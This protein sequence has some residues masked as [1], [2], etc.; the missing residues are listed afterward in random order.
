M[1]TVNICVVQETGDCDPDPADP[2]YA[3]EEATDFVEYTTGTYYFSRPE[4]VVEAE[5]EGIEIG[6]GHWYIGIQPD[7]IADDIAYA[8]TA[9]LKDC[10]HFWGAPYWGY[11]RWTPGSNLGYNYDLAWAI[12]GTTGGAPSPKAWIQPGTE[13]IDATVMNYGTF[14][15]EDLTCYAEIWEYITDPE[16]GTQVYSDEISNIDLTTPLGGSRDLQFADF[17]FADEGRYGLFLNLP[18]DPDD[19]TKNNVAKWGVAVDDTNPD[20]D[21][22]PIFDPADPTGEAGW[23][24][25]D[26]TVTLNASD[27]WSNGVSSGVKE[28]RYTINGG[29]EKVI[30]D[31]TGSFVLTEDGDDIEI[32]YWAV[33]WVGNVEPTKNT[34][35]IDIDQTVPEVDL[36][37]EVLGWT[38]LE[39]W[40][41]QFTATATD[42]MS[43]MESVEFYFNNELQSTVDGPGPTY[44]FTVFYIPLPGNAIFRSRAYDI[45]GLFSDDEIINPE[46]S[47]HSTPQTQISQDLPHQQPLPR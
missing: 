9:D 22:P 13:D 2:P 29:A 19:V 42:A 30:S 5:F 21:Y 33:D 7:G 23:Y 3:L 14:A 40:E 4:V 39:G 10:V 18:A 24:V 37:Y 27:P 17:T 44:V 34:I 16:N 6:P 47:S 46:T 45:A 32:Q 12:Y 15:Y 36:I 8:L 35:T 43:G 25:D 31:S 11:A 28:I 26:V 41:F 20:S 38:P 1:D